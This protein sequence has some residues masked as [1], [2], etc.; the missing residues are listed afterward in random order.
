[1][2]RIATRFGLCMLQPDGFTRLAQLKKPKPRAG[3]THGLFFVF[4]HARGPLHV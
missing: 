1:M 2:Y 3:S 4:A